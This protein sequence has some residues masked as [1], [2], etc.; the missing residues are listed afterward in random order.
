MER[1][2]IGNIKQFLSDPFKEK[3]GINK[4]L[5]ILF[6]LINAIIL[7]NAVFHDPAIGYDAFGYYD[8]I[9]VLAQGR[10]PVSAETPEFFSPPLP[11]M[12][13]A[14]GYALLNQLDSPMLNPPNSGFPLVDWFYYRFF[15]TLDDFSLAL[16]G[17]MTQLLNVLYSLVVS[18]LLLKICS[19]LRPGDQRFKLFSL[20][21]LGMMTVYY[22]LYAFVRAEPLMLAVIMACLY[23]LLW[24]W[25]QRRFDLRTGIVLGILAGLGMLTRQWFFSTLL[26]VGSGLL[27]MAWHFKIDW[28]QA[29]KILAAFAIVVGAI[30]APFYLHLQSNEGSVAAFNQPF[31]GV[32]LQSDWTYYLELGLD[33][34]F[35]DPIR[36]SL[37][38][39]AIPILYADTW[40]D[41]WAYFTVWG[42]NT[43]TNRFV[44]GVYL[45][46]SRL[47]PA[48]LADPDRHFESNRFEIQEYLARVNVASLL[49]SMI[50]LGGLVAAAPLVGSLF[51]R[52]K[53]NFENIG[54][55]TFILFI[56]YSV[57]IYFFFLVFFTYDTPGTI[58]AGYLLHIYPVLA[59]LGGRFMADLESRWGKF[60][61]V[62]L[63]LLLIVAAHNLPALLSNQVLWP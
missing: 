30:A 59:L 50:L 54:I 21:L 25:R 62:L 16:V 22:R 24:Y 34:V 42:R 49:P 45:D 14:A 18:F 12:P 17:K 57:T 2:R 6:I 40:G 63:A 37:T 38:V 41:Y 28:R 1:S 27:F 33:K 48:E 29:T 55:G 23:A 20:L 36:G 47:T 3:R 8:Y 61:I 32:A 11:F 35:S 56:F 4:P 31:I 44:Y 53:S 13:A 60:F 58:K 52:T 5:L 10:L 39:R 51:S 9:R 26:T 15:F 46:S 19:L 43:L 7:R